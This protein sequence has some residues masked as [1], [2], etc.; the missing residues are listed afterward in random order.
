MA[1]FRR[2]VAVLLC[3]SATSLG[4]RLSL[5]Q[6][7]SGQSPAAARPTLIPRSHEEREARYRALHH[8]ILNVL[9]VDDSKLPVTGLAAHDFVLLDNGQPQEL[10]TFREVNGDQAIAPPHVILILDAVNNTSRSVAFEIKEV[11]K[12]LEPNQGRLMFPPVEYRR[13]DRFCC[14]NQKPCS[15]TFIRMSARVH[16]T[17]PRILF[18]LPVTAARTSAFRLRRLTM[19]TA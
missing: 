17:M 1:R 9:A 6:A 8:I 2:L 15:E 18:R 11:G 3:I 19:G 4:Q 13:T 7:E 5:A 14:R 16:R 12:Y 10:A